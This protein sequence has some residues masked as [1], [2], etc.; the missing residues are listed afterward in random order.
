LIDQVEP[1]AD[2][3][4]RMVTQAVEIADRIARKGTLYGDVHQTQ[5][6]I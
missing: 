5:S 2:V 6:S 4:T 1:V 3:I